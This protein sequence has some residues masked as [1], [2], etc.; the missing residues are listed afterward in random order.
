MIG[1]VGSGSSGHCIA[2]NNIGNFLSSNSFGERSKF[3]VDFSNNDNENIISTEGCFACDMNKPNKRSKSQKGSLNVRDLGRRGRRLRNRRNLVQRKRRHKRNNKAALDA[4]S[5]TRNHLHQQN[6]RQKRS[7][8][9]DGFSLI[10]NRNGNDAQE[11][12]LSSYE[13]EHSSR[14]TSQAERITIKLSQEETRKNR[15]FC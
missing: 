14:N 5:L 1:A 4:K 12:N 9:I 11:R 2:L 13:Y 7:S 6:Q 8:L 10:S 15:Y 3:L